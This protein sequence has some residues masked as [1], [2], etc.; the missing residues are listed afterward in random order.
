MQ[1]EALGKTNTDV[2]FENMV[3]QE[4]MALVNPLPHSSTKDVKLS[5]C[6]RK[7]PIF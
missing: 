6:V 4:K 5:V 2:L 1:N 7:R 3:E